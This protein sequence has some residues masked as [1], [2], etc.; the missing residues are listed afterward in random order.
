MIIFV[1]LVIFGL[2][3]TGFYYLSRTA[4]TCTDKI[5]NQKET[6]TDCGGPCAACQ[7]MPNAEN[8]KVIEKAIVPG[9]A[10]KYDALVRITNP[11]SRLGAAKFDYSFNFLDGSG[12]IVA[13]S[14][15][16]NFILPGQ[17]KY[18]L[19]FN[20]SPETIPESLDFEISSFEWSK[21]LEYEEPDIAIYSKEFSLAGGGEIGFAKLQAKMRNQSGYDFRQITEKS[22][23]RNSNGDPVAINQTGFNDVRMN[24][25]RE[26][27]F[28]WS[29]T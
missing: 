16:T 28:N 19:A 23:I 4:P 15:G 27:N 18:V 17:T 21:F 7:E 3:G 11:N 12:K 6:G 5:Q 20:L 8:L 29:S 22:V 13:K 25:E 1:Y 2:I 26:I 9:E 24:E 14:I 10:G